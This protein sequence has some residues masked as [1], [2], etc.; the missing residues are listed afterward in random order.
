[1]NFLPKILLPVDVR[2]S[3]EEPAREIGAV[4]YARM[5]GLRFGSSLTLLHVWQ[6]SMTE[7]D[8]HWDALAEWRRHRAESL[9]GELSTLFCAELPGM[10]VE[11]RV[12]EGDP[13]HTIVNYAHSSES[14]LIVMPTHGYG[15]F[16][17]LL[18][19]SV[20]AKVLHDADC[21]V[22][23]GAHLERAAVVQ[24]GPPANIVCAVDLGPATPHV[25][26][27]AAR[28]A[29]GFDSRLFVV[30]VIPALEFADEGYYQQD[31]LSH[32]ARHAQDELD[33]LG[34]PARFSAKT[35]ITGG[36]VPYGVCSQAESLHADVVVIGRSSGSGRLR[37]NA[38]SIIRQSPCPVVSV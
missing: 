27:W 10:R 34:V 18:L 5:L 21:P 28:L 20:T 37:S 13:A 22:W 16:R 33:R 3:M 23:T 2:E 9:H 25:L 38:Y 6:H 19:G 11:A 31:W 17:R 8:T 14:S 15:G 26:E 32:L 1:M 30:H 4:H 7:A 24:P 36:N 35:V 29:G 12:M